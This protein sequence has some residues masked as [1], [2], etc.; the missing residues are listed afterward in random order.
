MAKQIYRPQD[1]VDQGRV[2]LH[3]FQ[4]SKRMIWTIIGIDN[5]YWTDLQMMFCSCKSYY[6]KPVSTAQSCY[7]LQSL[8][9][10]IAQNKFDKIE[11]HD[12]EYDG[13]VNA[14]ISDNVALL[15]M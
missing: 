6:Y 8:A 10:S 3:L 12:S 7:H 1:T 13:F 11:F 15:A 2:K 5:E 9:L 4:P 14:L